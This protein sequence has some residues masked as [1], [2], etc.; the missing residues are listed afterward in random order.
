MKEPLILVGGGGH[1]KACIDVIETE[2]RFEIK[3]II[4]KHDLVGEKILGYSIIGTDDDLPAL[5]SEYNNFFVTV[6]QIKSA[7]IRIKIFNNLKKLG[8]NIPVIISP[9]AHVSKHHILGEGT[10]IMHHVIV[11]AEVAIGINCIIN[12]KAL[13]EHEVFIDSHTHIST[14]AVVNGQCE[15]GRECFIGSNAVIANNIKIADNT[16]ISAGS[17]I[18]KNITESG[19]TFFGQKAIQS[20]K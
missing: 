5:A 3:G 15:V 14:G 19:N 7:Q 2:G 6:G 16:I 1:C 11:N 4:D 12:T 13:L 17:I 20:I 10:I 8:V 18:L 9:L